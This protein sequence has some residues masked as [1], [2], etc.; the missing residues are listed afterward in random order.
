MLRLSFNHHKECI[1]KAAAYGT[2]TRPAEK[3]RTA[4]QACYAVRGSG[5]PR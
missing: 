5:P 4:R 1:F 3:A 2:T